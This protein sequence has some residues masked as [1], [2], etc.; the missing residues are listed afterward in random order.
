MEK[1]AAGR[2]GSERRGKDGARF[3]GA[4]KGSRTS[5]ETPANAFVEAKIGDKK[6]LITKKHLD[7]FLLKRRCCTQTHTCH[8]TT[9][10]KRCAV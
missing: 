4:E 7:T 10:C 3:R 6:Q 2:K 8:Y 5:G 1:K 9:C